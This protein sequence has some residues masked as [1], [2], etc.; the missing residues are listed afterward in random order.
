MNNG[1]WQPIETAP[2]DGT[3]ILVHTTERCPHCKS[4]IAWVR[5]DG[6][7]RMG[8]M[9]DGTA[10]KFLHAPSSWMS[11]PNPPTVGGGNG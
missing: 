10:L 4:A 7:W 9:Q 1:E 11:G 8:T 3:S 6:F 2:K 5:W